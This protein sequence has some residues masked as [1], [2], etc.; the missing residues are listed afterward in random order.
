MATRDPTHD[1]IREGEPPHRSDYEN[2]G[3]PLKREKSLVLP[4][5]LVGLAA[6]PAIFF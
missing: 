3:Q 4:G 2:K 1:A 6:V 5:V